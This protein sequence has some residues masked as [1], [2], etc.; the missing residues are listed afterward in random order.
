MTV[1]LEDIKATFAEVKKTV[2]DLY[3]YEGGE[4]DRFIKALR[5][6]NKM[7]VLLV[8]DFKLLWQMEM[9]D[10]ARW[11]IKYKRVVSEVLTAVDTTQSDTS[12]V[13]LNDNISVISS[14][15]QHGN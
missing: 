9:E 6:V 13:G 12:T 5:A 15:S 4:S 8:G 11:E 3:R 14:V 2:E 7:D 1:T 10:A